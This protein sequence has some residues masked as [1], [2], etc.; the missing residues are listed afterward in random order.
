[1]INSK[2]ILTGA[3]WSGQLDLHTQVG[4]PNTGTHSLPGLHTVPPH[5][6]I[7]PWGV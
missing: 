2:T 3:Q 4:T 6:D 7:W 5:T 1:M